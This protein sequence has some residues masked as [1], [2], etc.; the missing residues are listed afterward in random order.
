M[1]RSV[2]VIALILAWAF[3]AGM[4]QAEIVYFL[5]GE[6]NPLNND[7][8][9]LALS[10]PADIA[11]ARD[12]IGYGPG[13]GDG[14]VVA[15]IVRSNPNGLNR[16]YVREG[17]P[18]WSWRVNAF[19]GFEDLTA[20]IL[21]GW[22]TW[23]EEDPVQWPWGSTIGFWS[24]T[25]VAEL[26]TDLEVWNC[27][28]SADGSIDFN[29]LDIFTGQWLEYVHWGPDVDGS[30]R[31]DFN[32]FAIIANHWMSCFGI[33]SWASYPKPADTATGAGPHMV[34]SWAAAP[35]AVSHYVYFGTDEAA[36]SSA[37]TTDA[38]VYMGNYASAEWDTD[39]YDSNGL[40]YET[41]YY[42][43]V[44]ERTPCEIVDGNTWSFTTMEEPNVVPVGW[45]RFDEGSGVTTG[46]SAGG[47]DGTLRGDTTWVS[48]KVGPYA[49]EF[50]GNGDWVEIPD[51]DSLDIAGQMTICAWTRCDDTGFT[52]I[53]AKQPGCPSNYWPGNY[54][55]N[56]QLEEL[57]F[58][59]ETV[60]CNDYIGYYS[61]STVTEG[62]WQHVAVTIVQGGDVN[63]YIDGS[64]AGSGPQRGTF[65][66]VNDEPVR[67]G[68]RNDGRWDFI[69]AID[70]VRIY[71][72]ALTEAEVQ[73]LYQDGLN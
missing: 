25:V 1:F 7:S 63:F 26:G 64:G 29:D 66:V 56:I 37:D 68:I 45:W 14:I 11:H 53:V 41:S 22:P 6:I 49:L 42:W 59:H 50:D 28:L 17:L 51:D 62:V 9:V 23:V 58:A 57:V 61:A 39:I 31:V 36:V 21:D 13:I 10:N 60:S 32:D 16:N 4:A 72:R 54:R 20:E 18:G 5:V 73:Q 55:F 3:L 27:D 70:D 30:Y 44:D 65:G 8:Y 24:Y 2:A 15:T 43:R 71:N 67:I 19:L 48:G 38:N 47:N 52:T 33:P 12:L 40:E 34:L 35:D 46:D 69:G